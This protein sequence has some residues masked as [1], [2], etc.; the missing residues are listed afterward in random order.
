MMIRLATFLRRLHRDQRGVS[1]VEFA[2]I[3]PVLITFYFGIAELTQGLMADRRT[4]HVASSIGDLVTQDESISNTEMTDILKIGKIIMQPFPTAT[5]KLRVTELTSN[6]TNVSKVVW[7]DASNYTALTVGSVVTP[8]AGVISA[9]QSVIMAEAVYTYTSPV[10]YIMPKPITFT[11]T[12]YLR[13]RRTDT[14]AR[15]P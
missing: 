10:Q 4:G 11:K 9:N 12:Y 13:P 8:P 5:L 7:S 15:V 6:S 3:A 2:F 1:A 14:I